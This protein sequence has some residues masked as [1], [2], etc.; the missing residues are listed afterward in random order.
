MAGMIIFFG[1]SVMLSQETLS[2]GM[3]DFF[4][5]LI[6]RGIGLGCLF[7]PLTTI[8]LSG[9]KGKDIAQGAGLTNMIRQLGGSFGVALIATFIDR[10]N[11]Y[12]RSVL[13]EHI[14]KYDSVA[15][16]HVQQIANF[17]TA[18]GASIAE[19]QAKAYKLMDLTVL[20]QMYLM[21]Y[22]DAF[23]IVGVFF[24]LCIPLLFLTNRNK[25]GGSPTPI[26]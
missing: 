24:L 23:Y 5:P 25:G 1:F 7:V 11:A 20:K 18:S 17:F 15:R 19:A 10:R 2:S 16:H 26:H 3:H 4:W 6:L 9:L 22:T 21:S 12:H 14:S 13:V 8:A